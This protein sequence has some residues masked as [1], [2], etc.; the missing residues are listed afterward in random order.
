MTIENLSQEDVIRCLAIQNVWAVER[1]PT[2]RDQAETVELTKSAKGRLVRRLEGA[3]S[4]ADADIVKRTRA[5]AKVLVDGDTIQNEA[6]SSRL[7]CR[8][9]TGTR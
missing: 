9:P 6:V 1:K 5:A 8:F 4:K 3:I 7:A 2:G